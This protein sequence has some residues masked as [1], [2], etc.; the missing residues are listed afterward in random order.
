[1]L[2]WGGGIIPDEPG[3]QQ[4]DTWRKSKKG[5][6]FGKPELFQGCCLVNNVTQTHV[7][8]PGPSLIATLHA[9]PTSVTTAVNPHDPT[10]AATY[11]PV[12]L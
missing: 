2:L 5:L 11:V 1:M 6:E 12:Y 10:T 4:R 8:D 7:H 3:E 9:P